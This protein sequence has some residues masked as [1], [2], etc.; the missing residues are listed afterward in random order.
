[1]K[2]KC[3]FN[4]TAEL[5]EIYCGDVKKWFREKVRI[6]RDPADSTCWRNIDDD[7]EKSCLGT[8]TDLELVLGIPV[9]LI[10]EVP[11]SWRG[12]E[13][14]FPRDPC[15]AYSGGAFLMARQ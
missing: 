10:L 4:L 14:D 5:N 2:P 11:S 6:N 9:M 15:Y 3:Y 7:G 13:W 12:N 8:A 1:M